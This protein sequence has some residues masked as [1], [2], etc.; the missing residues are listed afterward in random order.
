M[1]IPWFLGIAIVLNG[2]DVVGTVI[3]ISGSETGVGNMRLSQPGALRVISGGTVKMVPLAS[4]ESVVF[5]PEEAR[6]IN[7]E[8]CCMA[9]IFMRDGA[10]FT[11]RDKAHENAPVTFVC[12]NQTLLGTSQGGTYKANL[13]DIAKITF[14]H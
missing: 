8:F 7:G 9:D 14:V 10:H 3:D 12:V 5:F 1:K 4:V 2:C 6:T 13:A 11:S